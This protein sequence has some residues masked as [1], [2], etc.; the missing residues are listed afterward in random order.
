MN[1][2]NST[3]LYRS[4]VETQSGKRLGVLRDFDIDPGTLK[5]VTLHVAPVSFVKKLTGQH[6][7]IPVT[8]VLDVQPGL[9]VIEDA[10]VP[11]SGTKVESEVTIP[12][13]SP[14]SAVIQSES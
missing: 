1:Y 3:Q 8:S 5:I 12:N 10:S 4:I 9:I 7:L 13:A 14:S 6:L 11:V 2:I